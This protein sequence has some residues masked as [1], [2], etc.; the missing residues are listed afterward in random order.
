MA[1]RFLDRIIVWQLIHLLEVLCEEFRW[2][3]GIT[4]SVLVAS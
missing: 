4:I 2:L 3:S 1:L